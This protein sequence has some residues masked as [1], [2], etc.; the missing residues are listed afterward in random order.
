MGVDDDPDADRAL[1]AQLAAL[2]AHV[3]ALEHQLV[4]LW[5]EVETHRAAIARLERRAPPPDA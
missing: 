1:A 4:L 5:T 2:R 3:E